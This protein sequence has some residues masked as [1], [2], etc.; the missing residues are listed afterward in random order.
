MERR[1]KSRFDRRVILWIPCDQPDRLHV[2][3]MDVGGPPVRDS[4]GASKLDY[5]AQDIQYHRLDRPYQSTQRALCRL[6]VKKTR[7]K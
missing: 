7:Y 5:P 2:D 3:H 4:S 6:T 1:H